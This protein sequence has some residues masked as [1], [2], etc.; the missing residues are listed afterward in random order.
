[1]IKNVTLDLLEEFDTSPNI[2]LE[3]LDIW[4][5]REEDFGPEDIE[6]GNT[7]Y[8]HYLFQDNLLLQLAYQFQMMITEI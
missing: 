5:I 7:V 8:F 1:M 6:G 3:P 4:E 2:Y